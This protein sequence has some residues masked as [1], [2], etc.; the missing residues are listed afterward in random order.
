MF[1]DVNRPVVIV[2]LETLS[3]DVVVADIGLDIVGVGERIVWSDAELIIDAPGNDVDTLFCIESLCA[4][5][6]Y[7]SLITFCC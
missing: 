4:K 3:Y 1:F 5:S 6:K 7:R 2:A